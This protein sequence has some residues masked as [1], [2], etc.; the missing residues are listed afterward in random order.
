MISY[1]TR[2]DVKEAADFKQTARAD[3]RI[4]RALQAATL[5]IHGLCHRRFYPELATRLWDWPNGQTARPWRLWLDDNELISVTSVTS[6]GVLVPA[7]TVLLE[8]QRY[9]SP[10]NQIQLDISKT[11]GFIQ[12]GT[13]QQQISITGLFGYQNNETTTGT[14]TGALTADQT[15]VTVDGAASAELGVGSLIRLDDERCTVVGRRQSDTGQTLAADLAEKAAAV[16]LSVADSSGFVEGETVLV[17]SERMLIVDIAGDSLSVRRG[18]DGSTLAGHATGAAVYAPRTL[19]VRRGVLGTTAATHTSGA[20]VQRWDPPALV[21]Q[22]TIAEALV[23]AGLES[24][25]YSK[26]ARSSGSSGTERPKDNSGIDGLRVQ[27]Y[28][29]HGRKA[30]LRGV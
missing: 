8:P 24:S 12:A 25:G 15:T 10:Y 21:R 5:S 26:T 6:G 9:G 7:D 14:V 27:V 20:T 16:T 2:E 29:A 17:D 22:L 19:T 11:S 28:D 3:R 23:T 13:H 1:A 18:W 4:D 30:R